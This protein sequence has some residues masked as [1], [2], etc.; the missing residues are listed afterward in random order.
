MSLSWLTSNW[1]EYSFDFS[2]SKDYTLGSARD[3]LEGTYNFTGGE[4][5][6]TPVG[7]VNKY[8]NTIKKASNIA[9]G[10]LIVWETVISFKLIPENN[11]SISFNENTLTP[12]L[13]TSPSENGWSGL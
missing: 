12:H 4:T 1:D 3:R 2:K 11:C 10:P 13:P 5:F 9:A 8:K 7:K 6:D